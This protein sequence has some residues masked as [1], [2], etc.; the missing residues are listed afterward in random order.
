ML[1]PR[2]LT[3][4]NNLRYQSKFLSVTYCSSP[5]QISCLLHISQQCRTGWQTAVCWVRIDRTDSS[6]VQP[7]SAGTMTDMDLAIHE[8]LHSAFHSD[9]YKLNW[10]N[11]QYL[12]T[13]K[14]IFC[15]NRYDYI[16]LLKPFSS[17]LSSSTS[18]QVTEDCGCSQLHLISRALNFFK[19]RASRKDTLKP[20]KQFDST[21]T[22]SDFPVSTPVL[23]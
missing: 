10:H 17:T 18:S 11:L 23:V 1:I 7:L 16:Y 13:K 8:A 21:N 19:Q 6:N 15:D 22:S 4:F 3:F 14:K 5:A 12:T 20:I 9:L 2:D